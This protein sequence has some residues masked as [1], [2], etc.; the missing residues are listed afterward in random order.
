MPKKKKLS[1]SWDAALAADKK[2]QEVGLTSH[3]KRSNKILESTARVM[4]GAFG[5]QGVRAKGRQ[6]RKAKS[7]WDTFSGAGTKKRGRVKRGTFIKK[8][9]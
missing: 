6:L 2:R 7:L 1:S 3:Q 5:P 8:M 9:K 4:A